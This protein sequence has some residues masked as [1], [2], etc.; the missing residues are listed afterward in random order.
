MSFMV[1]KTDQSKLCRS[2]RWNGEVGSFS[3]HPFVALGNQHH[4]NV[5]HDGVLA[6]AFFTN[7]PCLFNQLQA[8]FFFF[9]TDW[10]SQNIKQILIYHIIS[11]DS[12]F[13]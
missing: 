12:N 4:W 6:S 5:F 13:S 10:T 9:Y 3:R 8:A 7:Q 1:I 11:I 2:W